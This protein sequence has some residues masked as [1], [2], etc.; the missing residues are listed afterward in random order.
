[1]GWTY[2]RKNLPDP[3]QSVDYITYNDLYGGIYQSQVIDVVQFLNKNFDVN[4]KL[5]AFVPAR[6]WKDQKHLIKSQF[7]EAKVY[8]ILGGVKNWRRTKRILSKSKNAICRGPMAVLLANGKYDKII[9]D[10]R[11]AVGAEAKEYNVG[12]TD[13]VNSMLIEAEKSALE[14]ADGFIA[15]SNKLK[16]YWKKELK[17]ELTKDVFVIPCT[18]TS[19]VNEKHPVESKT[20]EQDKVRV[21]YAGGTGP[22]Q[23]FEKVTALFE[24]ALKEQEN[25]HLLF[26]TKEHEAINKLKTKF[27]DRVERKWLKHEEVG[28][29]LATCD[30][31]IL[32]REDNW[33]NR[34]ASPVKFAEYLNAG[35]K[36]LISQE[37]GD[38]S[39]MVKKENIGLLVHDEIPLLEK[40]E[41]VEK[42]RIKE[43]CSQNFFKETAVAR[44]EYEGLMKWV[45]G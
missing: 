1:M 26:L 12:G 19:K 41:E 25:V 11:A 17:I 13:D 30:Y 32:I 7:P 24:R 45:N 33:T 18:L 23:S 5:K 34:V 42:E 35:L 40:V 20:I 39:S 44:R 6:L 2:Y 29:F 16:D 8:P 9:Y 3:L 31:G 14:L 43:F 28:S 38:F 10:A 4:I 27:D 21:V 37:L 22:W 36:V 15:V